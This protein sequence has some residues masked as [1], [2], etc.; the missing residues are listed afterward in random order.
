[1]RRVSICAESSEGTN[2]GSAF[3]S[4]QYKQIIFGG[5]GTIAVIGGLTVSVTFGESYSANPNAVLAGTQ[6]FASLSLAGHIG[7]GAFL[8]AGVEGGLGKS[9][10]P[11][12]VGFSWSTPYDAEAEGGYIGTVGASGQ[13]DP[14][15]TSGSLLVGV[16]L[17]KIGAGIGGYAGVGRAVTIT[18]AT[19]SIGG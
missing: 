18:L 16:P 13:I 19:P 6:F 8:G 1:M 9:N 3:P 11:L 12:P 4:G 17:P 10:G 5:T 7:L 14:N 15:G 2:G